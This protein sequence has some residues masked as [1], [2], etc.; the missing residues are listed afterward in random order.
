MFS[1]FADWILPNQESQ[2][3]VLPDFKLLCLENRENDS[4]E[5]LESLSIE[6]AYNLG[7]CGKQHAWETWR[8]CIYHIRM[9]NLKTS[10]VT[11]T[12]G[13]AFTQYIEYERTSKEDMVT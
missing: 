12:I 11:D 13:E 7:K 6:E 5:A 10:S 9:V 1:P 3:A 2:A 8:I 4:A